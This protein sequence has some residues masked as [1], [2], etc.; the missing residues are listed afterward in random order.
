[1]R[2]SV[3][4]L[5]RDGTQFNAADFLKVRELRDFHAIQ[6]HFPSQ[7]PGAQRRRLPVVLNETDV[8]LF[9]IDPQ[10]RQTF[11]IQLLDIV[12]S[13]LQH[14]LIL[15]V[16]LHT[17]WIFTVAPISGTTAGLG[18]SGAPGFR[19]QR[20]EKGRW[21]ECAGSHLHIVGLMNDTAPIGPK[22]V[23]GKNQILIIHGRSSL[24]GRNKRLFIRLRKA[25]G[26][27]TRM[28]FSCQATF[29]L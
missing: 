12:R 26:K 18:I 25:R 16:V 29:P 14:H 21:M 8:V 3:G 10:A 11:K 7:P 27:L 24:D 1:M 5:A 4:N 22:A 13:G 6:P 9:R 15:I 17:V 23:Q 28:L 20:P 19:S 2:C